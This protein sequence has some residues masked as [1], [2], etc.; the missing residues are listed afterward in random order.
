MNAKRAIEALGKSFF[1]AF[2]GGLDITLESISSFSKFVLFAIPILTDDVA[3]FQEMCAKGLAIDGIEDH[4]ND[5]FHVTLFKRSAAYKR[6]SKERIDLRKLNLSAERFLERE[7][8][9]EVGDGDTADSEWLKTLHFGTE[10]CQTIQLC[11]LKQRKGQEE[12]KETKY[13]DIE[14]EYDFVLQKWVRGEPDCG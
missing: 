3:R 4:K 6:K 13:Y 5:Q 10:H 14:A 7:R 12:L 11:R 9:I 2:P 8:E 1:V